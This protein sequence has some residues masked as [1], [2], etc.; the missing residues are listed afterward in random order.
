MPTFTKAYT[1]L[2]WLVFLFSG[3]YQT[4]YAQSATLTEETI[5]TAIE[6]CNTSDTTHTLEQAID[7]TYQPQKKLNDWKLTGSTLWIRLNISSSKP[8]AQLL[9]IHVAPHFLN[10]ITLYEQTDQVWQRQQAGS[11]FAFDPERAQLGG[12]TFKVR[13]Q[14]AG[15]QTFY[16]RVASTGIPFVLGR[17]I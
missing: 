17:C 14:G 8:Q 11:G 2:V 6:Y 7:C 12:Y 10:D 9:A 1:A 13:H 16:L 5:H 4:A 15:T 3:G